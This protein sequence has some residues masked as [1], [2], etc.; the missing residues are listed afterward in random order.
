SGIQ[1]AA[2]RKLRTIQ[3]QTRQILIIKTAVLETQRLMEGGQKINQLISCDLDITDEHLAT[4][5]SK[6]LS[7]LY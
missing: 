5:P 6:K 7:Q 4:F 3:L 1:K 2:A